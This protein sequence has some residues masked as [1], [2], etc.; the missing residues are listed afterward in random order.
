VAFFDGRSEIGPRALGHR[1]VMADPRRAE[2][3]PRVNRV[4]TRALW[5]PFAPA[6]LR[7][8][9]RDY[10]EGGPD[11]SPYMLFNATAK[12]GALPAVTHV[13][14]TS[15]V[16]TV[17]AENGAFHDVITAFHR[18]TGCPV[19]LNTS[20]NGPGEPIIETPAQALRFLRSAPRELI[21]S[22]SGWRVHRAD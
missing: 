15:R 3:W 5:R 11:N 16:Q 6:I 2:N 14:G 17:T 13:D 4:K 22:M 9:L 12:N 21:L 7:E 19:V 8:H 1:T 18:L 10:F 20:F